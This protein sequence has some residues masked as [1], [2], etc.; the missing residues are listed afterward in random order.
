M[1]EEQVR[2]SIEASKALLRHI[3][4]VVG[5]VQEIRGVEGK[6]ES[7]EFCKDDMLEVILCEDS[8]CSCCSPEYHY[9]EFPVRYLWDAGWASEERSMIEDR[10][11]REEE[12]AKEE[13]LRLKRMNEEYERKQLEALKAKYEQGDRV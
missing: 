8:R 9:I 12:E 2:S 11:K 4:T 7:H 5:I 6:Y 13:A 10:R 1:T 3:E